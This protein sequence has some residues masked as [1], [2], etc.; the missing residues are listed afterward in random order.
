MNK[1]KNSWVSQVKKYLFYL[2]TQRVE[3]EHQFIEVLKEKFIYFSDQKYLH[4][5]DSRPTQETFHNL[6]G[7][8]DHWLIQGVSLY[9]Y[10]AFQR[11]EN[12]MFDNNQS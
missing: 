11:R 4:P 9:I 5:F 10:H 8:E 7:T 6:S 1:D 2:Q 12:C 3:N